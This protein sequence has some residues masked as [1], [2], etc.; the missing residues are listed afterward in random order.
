VKSVTIE[1]SEKTLSY[2]AVCKDCRKCVFM[3]TMEAIRSGPK[4]P[5]GTSLLLPVT[6]SAQHE[7]EAH[8]GND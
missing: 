2:N 8:R 4:R 6:M 5:S 7:C 1:W 3:V